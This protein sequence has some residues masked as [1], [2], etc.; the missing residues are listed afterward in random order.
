MNRG[1]P[2]KCPYCSSAHT[3]PKGYRKTASLGL[4]K[5]RICKNCNRRFTVSGKARPTPLADNSKDCAKPQASNNTFM[6]ENAD[7]VEQ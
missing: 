5:L 6:A 4:R 3:R 7:T 2:S 1:R